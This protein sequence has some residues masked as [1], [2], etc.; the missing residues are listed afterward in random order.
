MSGLKEHF[1]LCLP[2]LSEED[3]LK[4]NVATWLG[5]ARAT[6]DLALDV[7]VPVQEILE[8]HRDSVL[9]EAV[10]ETRR[11]NAAFLNK[12]GEAAQS[13]IILE[14]RSAMTPEI[15][16]SLDKVKERALLYIVDAADINQKTLTV[17]AMFRA[18]ERE[19][20]QKYGLV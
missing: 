1:S 14:D 4:I 6:L 11:F 3:R 17:D 15:V 20:N 18:K 9:Q 10:E 12:L 16:E 19:W 2:Y 7:P 8:G 13:A 5:M